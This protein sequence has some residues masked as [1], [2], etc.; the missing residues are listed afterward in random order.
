MLAPR[1]IAYGVVLALFIAWVSFGSWYAWRSSLPP[2]DQQT[3][4]QRSHPT[5]PNISAEDRI[6]D[7]TWWVAAF[8]FALSIVS[9]FQIF[10]LI[11]ADKTARITATAAKLNAQALIAA[12][13]AKVDVVAL[14]S[15]IREIF[16]TTELETFKPPWVQYR[17]K[18]YGKSPA[19]IRNVLHGFSLTPLKELPHDVSL[20]NLKDQLLHRFRWASWNRAMEIVG[21]GEQSLPIRCEYADPFT[22]GDVKSIATPPPDAVLTFYGSASFLDS[23]GRKH[24]LNWEFAAFE[25]WWQLIDYRETREEPSA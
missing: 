7:Y 23:F 15:N 1:N 24:H 19:L 18:N 3:I 22:F 13:S 8:T 10:F 11:R 2:P 4:S 20:S 5:G 9:A 12:E 16:H 17:L 6:A 25:D 21:V 14:D